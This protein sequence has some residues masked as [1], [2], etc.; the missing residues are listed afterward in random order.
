MLRAAAGVLLGLSGAAEA[1]IGACDTNALLRDTQ[2]MQAACCPDMQAKQCADGLPDE[3]S[4]ACAPVF[5]RFMSTYSVG[6][7]AATLRAFEQRLDLHSLQ[8]Q[9]DLR[10]GA[11]DHTTGQPA[12][13]QGTCNLQEAL[14]TCQ[15]SPPPERMDD[16]DAVCADAC[17]A[18]LLPCSSDAQLV[19]VMGADEAQSLAQIAALCG[20]R[21]QR[22][23][24]TPGDGRCSVADAGRL[25]DQERAGS[26]SDTCNTPCTREML[27]CADDPEAIAILGKQSL[28]QL[29]VDCAEISCGDELARIGDTMMSRCCSDSPCPDG[30]ATSCSPQC[31]GAFTPFYSRCRA[32]LATMAAD[33]PRGSE[34]ADLV[35][36]LT[37][38]NSMCQSSAGG[39]H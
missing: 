1:Q 10:D 6:A 23:G 36:R 3:C 15:R 34:T 28:H 20:A 5:L 4:A 19:A 33:Q 39:G 32:Q 27:D 13:A 25:C 24:N 30:W 14:A 8:V 29:E 18:A 31:A 11:D 17:M 7:C 37:A 26:S 12:G 22:G 38:F 2:A 21:V 16:V 35:A 9:C